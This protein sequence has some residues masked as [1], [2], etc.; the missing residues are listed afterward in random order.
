MFGK[1]KNKSNYYFD[2]FGKI[3][4]KARESMKETY[5]FLQQFDNSKLA[6]NKEKIHKIEHEAD[7]Q[8][9]EVVEKLTTEFMTPIDREDIMSLLIK[10]DDVTDSI[11]EV[12]LRMYLYNYKE[13][14]KDTV[15]FA[16][17]ALNCVLATQDVMDNFPDF[18]NKTVMAPLIEKVRKYEEEADAMYE[19][20]MHQLY[21]ET[22]TMTPADGFKRHKGEAMY[23]MLEEIT[24]RCK[25]ATGFVETI[26]YK[27]I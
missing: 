27:N 14:P 12:S 13:L 22:D 25:I 6:E 23:N 20:K 11:E 21:I 26:M 10:I 3:F 5:A 9:H 24:D 16:E 2:S 17:L 19:E 7:L 8:K 15:P 4:T 1:K 18:M